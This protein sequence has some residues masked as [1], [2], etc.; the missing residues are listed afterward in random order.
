L[1]SGLPIGLQVIGR[2]GED[3]V[4]IRMTEIVVEALQTNASE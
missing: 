3:E 4:V 1:T 2:K